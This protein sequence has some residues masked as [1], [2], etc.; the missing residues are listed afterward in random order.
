MSRGMKIGL[1]VGVLVLVAGGVVG[2]PDQREEA[3][4]HRGPDGDR[5]R[6][7]TS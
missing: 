2:L 3:R 1:I 4:R 5:W 6:A 7:A